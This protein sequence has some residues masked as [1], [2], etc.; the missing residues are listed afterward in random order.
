MLNIG[1]ISINGTSKIDGKDVAYFSAS[2]STGDGGNYSITKNVTDKTLYEANS[3]RCEADYVE[4]ES[5]AMDYMKKFSM[6]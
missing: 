3:N 4:F 1:S 2:F 6:E 5:A